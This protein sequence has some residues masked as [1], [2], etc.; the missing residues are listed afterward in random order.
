MTSITG[1]YCWPQPTSSTSADLFSRFRTATST[2][3]LPPCPHIFWLKVH[4][5]NTC[6]CCVFA[7]RP[8]DVLMCF[9][10]SLLSRFSLAGSPTQSLACRM[11][12]F[13]EILRRIIFPVPSLRP[14]SPSLSHTS[15]SAL[16]WPSMCY[17]RFFLLY[18]GG[19]RR[20]F[21][22][23]YYFVDNI[24][25][26]SCLKILSDSAGLCCDHTNYR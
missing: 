20:C 14:T 4:W 15:D 19:S 25:T 8:K 16:R 6:H 17:K 26:W 5:L 21:F 24:I 18:C 1:V 22:C 10:Y 3:A 2:A 7:V 9:R 23:H 12:L 11:P 13:R